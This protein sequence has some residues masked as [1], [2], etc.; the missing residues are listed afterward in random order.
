MAPFSFSAET[1]P[2]LLAEYRIITGAPLFWVFLLDIHPLFSYPHLN[3]S[4]AAN[5]FLRFENSILINGFFEL[6]G[7][8]EAKGGY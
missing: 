8:K 4:G 2:I 3:I 6:I 7:F 1:T 5:Q